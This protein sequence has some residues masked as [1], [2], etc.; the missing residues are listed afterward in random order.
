MR[1]MRITNAPKK[2]KKQIF[3]YFRKEK[4]KKIYET[5]NFKSKFVGS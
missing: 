4:R 2:E 5:N 1:N 3:I